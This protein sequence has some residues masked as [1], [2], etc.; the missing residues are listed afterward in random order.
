MSPPRLGPELTPDGTRFVVWAPRARR[1]ELVLDDRAVPLLRGAD[2]R[3]AVTTDAPP[4]TRYRLRLDG[5]DPMPDPAS[6]SQPDGVH[7][8]SEVVD[9][10]AF[11]WTQRDWAGVPLSRLRI[12]E[13][14]VG[15]FTPEGTFEAAARRLPE[16]AELGITAIELMPVHDFPGARGWGYD[17]AAWYAPCRAYGRPEDLQR[18]VDDA[19]AC[20]LSVILDVVYNHVGPDGAYVCAFG[21][22]LRRKS[23][24]WGRAL[25]LADRG[26]RDLILDN[27]RYWL[28]EYRI[29]G[30][31]L[32]ATDRLHDEHDPHLLAEL[33]LVADAI[34]GA[35]R[36]L[37]AEDG[38]NLEVILRPLDYGGMA[39]DAVWADD[40]HHIVR[41]I[42]AGDHHGYFAGVPD[43]V[44]GLAECLTHRWWRGAR[45]VDDLPAERFVAYLQNHDQIG[46]RAKGDRLHASVGLPAVRAATGLLLFA[47][48]T[49][50]LFMGQEHAASTPFL[51]F[52][53]HG[54][55]VGPTIAEGR[56]RE[57]SALPGFD[58]DVPDPQAASTFEAS[59][60]RWDER[61][62]SPHAEILALHRALLSLRDDLRGQVEVRHVTGGGLVL[63]RGRHTLA[64]QLVGA[65][66][67]PIPATSAV[68]L[69][70]EDARFGGDPGAVTRDGGAL[71]FSR[72]GAVV[73]DTGA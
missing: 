25:N 35:P 53:D 41:R 19:H 67:L 32:D 42:V 21:P 2:G 70:T 11:E 3:W 26:L 31:R 13:L 44:R 46:N 8:A 4:G 62:R 36:R 22:V 12:Y 52:S 34:E 48:H 18:F 10:A 29:D 66:E 73:L 69:S 56:R 60:I 50:L 23:T 55:R 20:G 30:L 45:G 6:R 61:A 16:L 9:L 38:R 57:L 49:P 17:P 63:R 5:G 47:A 54:P 71:R 59:K 40:L 43:T 39:M 28:Q 1:V 51:F 65:D 24:P 68:A 37:I 33:R 72:P 64:V 15:A 7:G 27:A 58:G 14:H